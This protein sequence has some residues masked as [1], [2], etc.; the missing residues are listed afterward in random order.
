[1]FI[2]FDYKKKEILPFVVK[3]LHLGDTILSE[4]SQTQRDKYSM[5]FH[6]RGSQ[7]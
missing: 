7:N 5:F 2:L 4:T 1:M 3:W 6:I